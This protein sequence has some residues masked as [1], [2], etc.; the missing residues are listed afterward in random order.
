MAEGNST[1]INVSC[2]AGKLLN[3]I[4]HLKN[5]VDGTNEL[6]QNV[7]N[8]CIEM[9]D[10]LN[11]IRSINEHCH[12]SHWHSKMHYGEDG[13]NVGYG[14]PTAGLAPGE[15]DLLANEAALG[16]DKDGNGLVYALDFIIDDNDPEKPM[17]LRDLD[18]QLLSDGI[19]LSTNLL[20]W[21]T[22]LATLPWR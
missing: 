15:T 14:P 12:D 7:L 9:R 22:F 4:L 2:E 16:V 11:H 18:V 5:Q 3:P 17:S 20:Y 19:I 6:L 13:F 8:T 21:K 1:I 10:T